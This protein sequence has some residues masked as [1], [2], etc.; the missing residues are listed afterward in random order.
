M[1]TRTCVIIQ[2][3]ITTPTRLDNFL[4]LSGD[5]KWFLLI[6]DACFVTAFVQKKKHSVFSDDDTEEVSKRFE[7]VVVV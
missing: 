3:T 4:S 5:T 6:F 1:C 2:V 7:G